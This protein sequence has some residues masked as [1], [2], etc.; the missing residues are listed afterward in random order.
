MREVTQDD[1]SIR[2]LILGELKGVEREELEERFLTNADFREKV[3][4]AEDDLIDAFLEGELDGSDL[5]EFS[6]CSRRPRNTR[7]NSGL[8]VQSTGTRKESLS[9]RMCNRPG[10][11][12]CF[13]M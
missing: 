13:F 1:L 4:M 12:I 8:H 6:L 3:L 11:A 7:V 9:R 2:R 10:D 5:K